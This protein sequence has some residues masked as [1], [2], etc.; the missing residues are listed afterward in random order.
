MATLRS[1]GERLVPAMW[2]VALSSA[3][4]GVTFSLI[5]LNLTHNY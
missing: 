4:L 1:R 3:E 2:G 5:L